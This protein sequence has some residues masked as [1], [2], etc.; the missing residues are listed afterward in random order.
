MLFRLFLLSIRTC[1]VHAQ[2]LETKALTKTV[3]VSCLHLISIPSGCP[4][5]VGWKQNK[6]RH[7]LPLRLLPCYPTLNRHKAT[8]NSHEFRR[9]SIGSSP[10][11][12]YSTNPQT[13]QTVWIWLCL[14]EQPWDKVGRIDFENIATNTYIPRRNLRLVLYFIQ[15]R[16]PKPYFPAPRPF[17]T[18]RGCLQRIWVAFAPNSHVEMEKSISIGSIF[19]FW[20]FLCQPFGDCIFSKTAPKTEIAICYF[21]EIR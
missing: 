2:A 5:Q 3:R 11:L 19:P 10:S 14:S 6:L 9:T 16:V 13:Q 8:S 17:K 18:V 12:K 21:V 15:P 4:C 20:K 1:H 7:S